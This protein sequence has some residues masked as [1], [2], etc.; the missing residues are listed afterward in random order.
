MRVGAQA[1]ER[2]GGRATARSS[3]LSVLP[4]MSCGCCCSVPPTSQRALSRPDE[5][6][7]FVGLFLRLHVHHTAAQY[8]FFRLFSA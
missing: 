6:R 5:I 1:R 7:Q 8:V 3:T 2:L 4:Y